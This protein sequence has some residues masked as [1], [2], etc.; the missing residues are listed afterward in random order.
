[1]ENGQAYLPKHAACLRHISFVQSGD[2]PS[3]G[4]QQLLLNQGDGS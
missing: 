4:L 2:R 1:M 3:L